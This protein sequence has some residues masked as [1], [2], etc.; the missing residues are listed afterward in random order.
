M[1]YWKVKVPAY[2]QGHHFVEY[3]VKATRLMDL[4]PLPVCLKNLVCGLKPPLKQRKT[5]LH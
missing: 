5:C 2:R 1:Y 3:F 4:D